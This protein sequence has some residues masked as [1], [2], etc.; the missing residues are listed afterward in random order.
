MHIDTMAKRAKQVG[1]IATAITSAVTARFGWLQ[2]E[3]AVTSIVYAVGLGLASFM[4]GYGLVFAWESRKRNMPYGVTIASV[5]IFAI[6]VVVEVLSHVGANASARTH[7]MTKASE[8]T[9]TYADTRGQLEQARAD[10]AAIKPG[11]APAQ[12]SADMAN[13]ETRPWFAGTANCSNPGGYANSCRRY[14]ALKGELA[15]AQ[16]RNMLSQKVEKLAGTSATSSAGHS[17]A[18]A[19]TKAIASYATW[20][21]NPGA[22][23]QAKTNMAITLILALYFVSLGLINLVAQ[24]FDPEDGTR[25]AAQPSAEIIHPTFAQPKPAPTQQKIDGTTPIAEIIRQKLA[26]AS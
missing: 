19:Q 13:I 2:G 10:L 15:T 4:V 17:V 11:R 7:D 24:A 3:D 9:N 26:A 23:D 18:L 25:T 21:T 14:N 12:I 5:A 1:F 8:Q 20:N 22:E 16:N 6:A